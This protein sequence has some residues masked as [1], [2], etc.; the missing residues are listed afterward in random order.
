MRFTASWLYYSG[1][2]NSKVRRYLSSLLSLLLFDEPGGL[3]RVS[4]PSLRLGLL[5]SL[6]ADLSV[7]R[8]HVVVHEDVGDYQI[9]AL[10]RKL[11]ISSASE[12]VNYSYYCYNYWTPYVC[13]L[14]L[15]ILCH[16]VTRPLFILM[17]LVI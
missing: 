15:N 10:P 6:P 8:L 11:I 16:L 7:D 1:D 14:V 2:R 5:S 9:E 4:C 12:T 13:L 3:V 17:V